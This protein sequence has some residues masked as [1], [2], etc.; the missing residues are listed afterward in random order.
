MPALL[1]LLILMVISDKAHSSSYP[2]EEVLFSMSL[3]ELLE[4][5]FTTATL[6]PEKVDSVP[7]AYS[8][9][10]RNEI[11]SLGARY[12]HELLEY[13]PGFQVTR[14]A[15]FSQ[16][17]SIT[18]RGL[19]IGSSSRKILFLIDGFAANDPRSGSAE[20]LLNYSLE[21]VQKVEVLRGPGSAI[22]G[23]NAFTGVVNIITRSKD[24][25]VR[26]QS[27]NEITSDL[28]VQSYKDF[29]SL[30]LRGQVSLINS[31][32]DNYRVYDYLNNANKSIEDP[33]NQKSAILTLSNS[34]HNLTLNYRYRESEDFFTVE[35][36]SDRYE[37]YN[38]RSMT[39]IFYSYEFEWLE[40]I[41]SHVDLSYLVTELETASQSTP[42]GAFINLSIPNSDE[43]FYGIG[44]LESKG[45]KASWFN[46]YHYGEDVSIQFGLS[47]Q[48]SD[49]TRAEGV[50]NFDLN[51]LV[52]G[53]F[54]IRYSSKIDLPAKVGTEEGQDAAGA[55]FQYQHQ[56]G[57]W[58]W[59]VGGRYDRFESIGGRFTPRIGIVY[60]SGNSF[61]F[62]ALYGQAFRSPDLADLNLFNG[63]ARKGNDSLRFESTQSFDFIVQ[64]KTSSTLA[65]VNY[66][67]TSYDDPIINTEI[68]GQTTLINGDASQVRGIEAEV[69]HFL[70]Q[71]LWIR[72]AYTQYF[73]LP[74]SAF[75]ESKRLVNFHISQSIGEK[76]LLGLSGDY[77]SSRRTLTNS[78][79]LEF[80]NIKSYW[81]F[82][83]ISYYEFNDRLTFSLI[84]NNLEGNQY[85][86]PALGSGLPDGVIHPGRQWTAG[87]E[88][89]F[90]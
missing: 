6:T 26:L 36:L 78:F 87:F 31:R 40:S 56:A 58:N 27:G 29:K 77:R 43:P 2:D 39:G 4:A 51:G 15:D 75:R 64:Y 1:M 84:V 14:Y 28:F 68:D 5:K 61:Q 81:R 48:N 55:F 8:I 63:I 24:R 85:I 42:V 53:D 41:E 32:G 60:D 3:D 44:Y 89:E 88:W 25:R 18:S 50:T 10:T 57:F 21:H 9:F 20:N 66:F 74:D 70:N 19:N 30:S 23:S 71:D 45:L 69:K 33:F 67:V 90:D 34:R 59:I 82:R 65:S 52:N 12:L 47:V 80:N 73:E 49:E 11:T 86:G 35:R 38:I 37:N 16:Q 83:L 76:I 7:A 22:Y 79:P 54:P 46:N 13:A 72:V 62:K 17:Y